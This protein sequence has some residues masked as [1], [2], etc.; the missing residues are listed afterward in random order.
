MNKRHDKVVRRDDCNDDSYI[1]VTAT[2]DLLKN[3][4]AVITIYYFYC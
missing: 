3:L 4:L 1:K 2:P